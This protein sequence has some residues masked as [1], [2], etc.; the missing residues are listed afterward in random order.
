MG[1]YY[2]YAT[3]VIG[4]RL[5]PNPAFDEKAKAHW[6]AEKYYNDPNYYNDKNL[7]KPYRVAMSCGFCHYSQLDVPG[8]DDL[9][10]ACGVEA[11]GAVG[12]E[13][14]EMAGD[15]VIGAFVDGQ[16]GADRVGASQPI[17][18]QLPGVALAPL[19]PAAAEGFGQQGCEILGRDGALER[20]RGSAGYVG[21]YGEVHAEAGDDAVAAALEQDAGKLGAGQHEVVRPFQ[22]EREAAGDLIGGFDQGQAGG[23]RQR[24]R[25]RIAGSDVDQCTA[26]EIAVG[27][28]PITALTA[29]PGV[30]G[31]R[32]QPIA[33]L[34]III[35]KQI[36]VGRAGPLDDADVAQKS[37]P[38]A[39]SVRSCSGPMSR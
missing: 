34:R 28:L 38:A 20:C 19:V 25:G 4:L 2:G 15:G 39:R 32:D 8:A 31:Q 16:W 1:S 10:A 12:F 36:G 3:G 30:L 13:S 37:D 29:A 14:G 27:G 5:F 9:R 6:D 23:K 17:L 26:E 22:L 11:E 33:F 21:R 18:H 7:V 35:G 24:R